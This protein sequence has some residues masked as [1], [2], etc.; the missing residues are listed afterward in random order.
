M[1]HQNIYDNET[2][3]AGYR[4]IRAN[5]NNANDLF[6][7][8]ALLSLLPELRGC[9]VLDLGCGCGDHC[10]E[11]IRMGAEQVVGVDISKKML[12]AAQAENSH[13]KITYL[14]MPMESIG[15]LNGSFDVVTSSLA[16]HYVEDFRG[17]AKDIFSLLKPGGF[18]VFS[19]ENPVN[20]CFSGGSRWTRDE[21]GNKLYAHLADY[22]TDGK[23][24]SEWFVDGVVKYHRTFSSIVNTLVDAGFVIEQMIE[25]V[26]DSEMMAKHPE[27]RDLIHKPDFLLVRA[28]KPL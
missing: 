12:A 3:F 24:Q 16:V 2:F 18:F 10:A 26:P 23:R 4:A 17:L 21:Q 20:T 15:E 1:S 19:Q 22:S 11:F 7:T 8:P 28:K 25:P 13:P 9:A 5:K 27:H 14:N 6:E